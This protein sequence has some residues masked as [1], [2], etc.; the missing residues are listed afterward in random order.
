MDCLSSYKIGC[1]I[2]FTEWIESKEGGGKLAVNLESGHT[3]DADRIYNI[4]RQKKGQL[5]RGHT[6]GKWTSCETPLMQKR[7]VGVWGVSEAVLLGVKG[8][9]KGKA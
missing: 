4:S 1:I 6:G 5:P 9:E 3:V 7:I 8:E 2:Y